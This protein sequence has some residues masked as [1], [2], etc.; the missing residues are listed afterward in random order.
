MMHQFF[1][2]YDVRNVPCGLWVPYDQVC[3]T[4]FSNSS[5]FGI[6]VEDL[7]CVRTGHSYES[8]F[9]HFATVL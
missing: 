1:C 2:K 9:I 4:A 3:V 7:R 6:K 5:F 8:I